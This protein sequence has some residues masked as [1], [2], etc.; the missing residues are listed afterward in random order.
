MVFEADGVVIWRRA[1][2]VSSMDLVRR[3]LHFEA[4]FNRE[5]ESRWFESAVVTGPIEEELFE[6]LW[7]GQ[8]EARAM[9]EARRHAPGICVGHSQVF[10]DDP[11][12]ST[13]VIPPVM[14]EPV[15][16]VRAATTI[17]TQIPQIES[18]SVL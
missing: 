16:L 3:G 8:P 1:E 14:E 17:I 10:R 6:A 5:L 2:G 9:F 12:G 13:R 4:D 7:T 18:P 11:E 15:Q